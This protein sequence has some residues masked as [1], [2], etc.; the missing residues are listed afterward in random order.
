M[1]PDDAAASSF[2][3]NHAKAGAGNRQGLKALITFALAAM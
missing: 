1:S 2:T 3:M